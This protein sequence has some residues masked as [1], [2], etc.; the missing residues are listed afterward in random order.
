MDQ[1][2]KPPRLRHGDVIALVSP[3]SSPSPPEKIQKAALYLESLGYRVKVGVHAADS[4]GYLAGKDADRAAEFNAMVAD[5]EVKAIFA[6]RGGYG[7][8]RLLQSIDYRG[9]R[10]NPKIIAGFSDIT[11]LQLAIYRKTRLVTFS[12]P[13]PAVE[14]CQTP[15]RFTEENFWPLLTSAKVR[16]EIKNGTTLPL[17]FRGNR[18]VEGQLLGGNLSLVVSLLGTRFSPDYKDAILVLEDVDE[19]P[20]RIDRMLTQLSN[21]AIPRHLRGIALGQFTRCENKDPNKPSLSLE[22]VLADFLDSTALPSVLNVQYGHIPEKL[23]L[24]IGVRA[25]IDAKKQR[26][27]LMEGGV[28]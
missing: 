5:P 21:A 25:R 27:E 23:T 24:P 17:S 26:L 19:A 3:A 1:N 12:G 22:E 6:T 13:M 20:Y 8:P 7:S 10:K 28:V 2:I 16:G 11:A 14:F 18:V 15:A 9:L 4:H